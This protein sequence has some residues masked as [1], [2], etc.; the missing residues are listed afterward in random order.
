MAALTSRSDTITPVDTPTFT[1]HYDQKDISREVTPY[2]L[3]VRFT[4]RLAGE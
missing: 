4:D 2:V 3:S 1:L